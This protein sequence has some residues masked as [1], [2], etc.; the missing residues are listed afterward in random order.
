MTEAAKA[1]GAA[2][3]ESPPL[4]MVRAYARITRAVAPPGPLPA[5][6]ISAEGRRALF[7]SLL[8]VIPDGAG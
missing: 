4:E 6:Q 3:A 8:A 1:P 5:T 2:K 7:K